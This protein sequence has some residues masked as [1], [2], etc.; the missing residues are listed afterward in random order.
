MTELVLKETRGAVALL[1][2]NRPDKLNALSYALID[3]LM[4]ILNQIE[5]DDGIRAIILTGAGDRAFA[6]CGV[7]TRP[8]RRAVDARRGRGT[9]GIRAAGDDR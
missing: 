6:A 5:D 7:A 1:I 4:H 3:R 9:R 2:L 8:A